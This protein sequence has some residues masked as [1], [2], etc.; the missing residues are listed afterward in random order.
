MTKINIVHLYEF[1]NF[2]VQNLFIW[3]NLLPQNVFWKISLPSVNKKTLSKD[4]FTECQIWH[5]AKKLFAECQIWHSAK[6]SLPSV[7]SLP[8]VD[9]LALGKELLCRVLEK[10]HSAKSLALGKDLFSGSGCAQ[11]GR[12]RGCLWGP[13]GIEERRGSRRDI[14]GDTKIQWSPSGLISSVENGMDLV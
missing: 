7:F 8:S 9:S 2:V 12:G 3:V 6:Q 4:C 14:L 5:S 13:H 10:K 11:W 1:N